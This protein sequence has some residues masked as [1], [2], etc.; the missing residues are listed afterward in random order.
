MSRSRALRG[1]TACPNNS[2]PSA[3]GSR[4][5]EFANEWPSLMKVDGMAASGSEFWTRGNKCSVPVI[6][7]SPLRPIR[8]RISIWMWTACSSQKMKST[9]LP[10]SGSGRS[11]NLWCRIWIPIT[12]SCI[13]AAIP[14]DSLLGVT[15]Y[16]RLRHP[17][18]IGH[19]LEGTS[20]C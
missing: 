11:C 20:F 12:Q 10:S 2:M 9:L 13:V 4:A 15:R 19:R 6:T 16:A 17:H 5:L 8:L 3:P 7:T 14:D 1:P 18:K